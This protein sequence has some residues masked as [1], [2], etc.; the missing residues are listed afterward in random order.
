MPHQETIPAS[1]EFVGDTFP[2]VICRTLRRDHRSPERASHAMHACQLAAKTV[3]VFRL[4]AGELS[5]PKR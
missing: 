2:A 4:L 5:E 1:R 3:T